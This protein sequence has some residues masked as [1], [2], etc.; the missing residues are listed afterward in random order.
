MTFTR[1]SLICLSMMLQISTARSECCTKKTVGA[2]DYTLMGVEDTSSYGCLDT[3]VYTS[4]QNGGKFCFSAGSE[5][6]MCT[7]SYVAE[8]ETQTVITL[9]TNFCGSSTS[10]PTC[11]C[12]D[13]STFL[14]PYYFRVC[15]DGS[16]PVSCVCPNSSPFPANQEQLAALG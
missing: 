12:S 4:V 5:A 10:R 1:M 3:C 13:S 6:S 8:S 11:T 14:H 7:A 16:E 2:V 9:F 15:N